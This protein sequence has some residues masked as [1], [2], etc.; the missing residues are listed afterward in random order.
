MKRLSFIIFMLVCAIS[1]WTQEK[2]YENSVE[3]SYEGTWSSFGNEK[4]TL[5]KWIS[6]NLRYPQEAIEK[7]EQ[8]VVDVGF[9]VEKDGSLSSVEITKSVSQSL[10]AEALRL[11]STM[12]KWNC[13]YYYGVP[14]RTRNFFSVTFKLPEVK[15]ESTEGVYSIYS[16]K[17]RVKT[18][19]LRLD[20]DGKVYFKY[21]G[22]CLGKEYRDDEYVYWGKWIIKKG[23]NKIEAEVGYLADAVHRY[24]YYKVPTISTAIHL[25][26][27]MNNIKRWL[28]IY[29]P[30]Y[31]LIENMQSYS[32]LEID[33]ND[34]RIYGGR[35]SSSLQTMKTK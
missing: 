23:I 16:V 21:E 33:L 19:F 34:G 5:D 8:G 31:E 3:F 29:F 35:C 6:S 12:P 28:F 4:N 14:C 25:E 2:I 17:D 18:T 10:D 30:C 15:K 20:K 22:M 24:G 26:Q 27:D 11:A 13:A 7:R 1:S 9:V 32:S